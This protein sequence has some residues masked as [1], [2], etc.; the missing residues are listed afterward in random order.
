MASII[1]GARIAGEIRQEIRSAV[2]ELKSRG[3]VPGLAAVL[4]GDDPASAVY[5]R[6]KAKACEDVG[7]RSELHHLHADADQKSLLALVDSLN[8][9]DR[10]HGILVQLPL[11]E[12]IDENR[13][14]DSISPYKDVDG[15]HPVNQGLLQLGRATLAPCTP[16]GVIELLHRSGVKM[17][18]A[19][20]V[21]VGRSR[22]V[23]MPLAILC[24]QKSSKANATVTICHSASRQLGEIT[25]QADI[26]VAAIGK[27]KFLHG[28]MIKQNAVVIDVGINRVEDAS[29]P[30]GYRLVGDVDFE[31]AQKVARMITPVPGGVGPM[32]IAMLLQNT[33]TA[34]KAHMRQ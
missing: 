32:T 18:G 2:Q 21:V 10:I 28:G 16:L 23:G 7:M 24:A 33:V 26:L 19:H 8:Q 3:I 12:H 31:S 17:E 11:P 13:I 6:N 29:S 14:L 30:R 27:P 25:K 4:V 9:D 22:L 15:L 1:D 5:V 34:A 20:V